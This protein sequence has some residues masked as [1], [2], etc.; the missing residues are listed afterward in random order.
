MMRVETSNSTLQP[1][2]KYTQLVFHS[3]I[4]NWE[5]PR[6]TWAHQITHSWSPDNWWAR[7]HPYFT[8][9]F[10][11]NTGISTP[12]FWYRKSC[13]PSAYT[14]WRGAFLPQMYQLNPAPVSGRGHW[15]CDFLKGKQRVLMRG[16][17][18]IGLSPLSVDSTK[19]DQPATEH[20]LCSFFRD[21][22][23]QSQEKCFFQRDLFIILTFSTLLWHRKENSSILCTSVNSQ[24]GLQ[25]P[26][27]PAHR[28]C[29]SARLPQHFP[30]DFSLA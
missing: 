20:V 1:V 26:L 21:V 19:P 13:L 27:L 25:N 28:Y 29:G 15:L 16:I 12:R 6:Q 23:G 9:I 8:E 10:Q 2:T 17:F 5:L 4:S 11:W 24:C 3:A 30:A 18:H 7:N 22:A 14:C